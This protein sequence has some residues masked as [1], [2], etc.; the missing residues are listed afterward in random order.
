MWTAF[1]QTKENPN[2]KTITVRDLKKLHDIVSKKTTVMLLYSF[3]CVH[4]R[5]FGPTWDKV[6]NAVKADPT[7]CDKVQ[8]VAIEM[9]VLVRLRKKN[10]DL[11]EFIS[12]TTSSPD[13]YFPKLMFFIKKDDNVKKV[14][15]EQ[16][17]DEDKLVKFI[18]SKIPRK[19]RNIVKKPTKAVSNKVPKQK[20]NKRSTSGKFTKRKFNLNQDD[21]VDIVKKNLGDTSNRSLPS[22]IDEMMQKYMNF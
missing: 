2:V 5:I 6:V 12:T 7:I 10:R 13:L 3:E 8:F 11:F 21:F 18:R 17:R 15:Y 20:N 22:L 4:C 16:D 19:D 14:V 9:D 1:Q